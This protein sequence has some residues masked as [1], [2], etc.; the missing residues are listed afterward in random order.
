[1]LRA[2]AVCLV[3]WMQSVV[4]EAAPVQI[5]FD[6]FDKNCDVYGGAQGGVS[7]GSQNNCVYGFSAGHIL[8]GDDGWANAETYE[9]AEGHR[10]D[11]QS[12]DI[13]SASQKI[14]SSLLDPSLANDP[15]TQWRAAEAK[16]SI[17][18][19][20]LAFLEITGYRNGQEVAEAHVDVFGESDLS[21]QSAAPPLWWTA[22]RNQITLSSAFTRLDSLTIRMAA[23]GYGQ[24]IEGDRVY[25]CPDER[26]GEIHY[27]D[28]LLDAYAVPL[29]GAAWMLGVG[30]LALGAAKHRR[31]SRHLSLRDAR[32]ENHR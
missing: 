17:N 16:G 8:L 13:I 1:M 25:G 20:R 24:W 30:L 19:D 11:A 3:F 27:D 29:P 28:L 22:S 15:H 26:C 2:V 31:C 7:Y 12:F 4:A 21:P 5:T 6:E 18:F 9:A 32:A 10:F 23:Y 14:Y